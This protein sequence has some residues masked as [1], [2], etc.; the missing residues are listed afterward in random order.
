MKRKIV[1]RVLASAMVV[2]AAG[3]VVSPGAWAT[4]GIHNFGGYSAPMTAS[5]SADI[6]VPASSSISCSS[7]R[8]AIVDMWV[9]LTRGQFA[10]NAGLNVQC[11]H[12]TPITFVSGAA[13]TASFRFPVSGGDVIAISASETSTVT[14]VS[15]DD[16]TT[17]V[18]ETANSV[19]ATPTPT[20]VQFGANSTSKVIPNFG[21]VTFSSVT[22]DGAPITRRSSPCA[23]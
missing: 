17:S 19:G 4:K 21:P 23:N 9:G 5:A 11:I 22:V 3:V 16:T 14:S 15:A 7:A 20:I 10:A 12:G 8:A 1:G 6:T 2:S 13:G 18:N